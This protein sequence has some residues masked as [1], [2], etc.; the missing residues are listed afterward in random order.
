[1]EFAGAMTRFAALSFIFPT[2]N[3]L[4]FGMFSAGK[5]FKLVLMAGFAGFATDQIIRIRI[6][7]QVYG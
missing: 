5:L 1:M 2:G 7:D 3:F 6:R 4:Q